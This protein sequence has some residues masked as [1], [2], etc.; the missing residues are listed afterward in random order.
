M[1][2][3][4]E[5][6]L[7]DWLLAAT[8]LYHSRYPTFIPKMNTVP[9]IMNAVFLVSVVLAQ[10]PPQP[11]NINIAGTN[12]LD[13]DTPISSFWGQTFLKEN[14]PYIVSHLISNL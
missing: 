6:F 9:W 7:Q 1:H 12:F 10:G 5:H 4:Q 11:E 13:H 2:K 8:L 3:M 14:I